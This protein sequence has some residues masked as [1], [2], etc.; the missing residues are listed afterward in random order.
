MSNWF[1]NFWEIKS[2]HRVFVSKQAQSLVY[3]PGKEFV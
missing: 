3:Q 2:H 1:M